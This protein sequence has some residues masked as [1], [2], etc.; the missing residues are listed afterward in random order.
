MGI[1]VEIEK[2][3]KTL[4]R[5]AALKERVCE[6]IQQEV[7]PHHNTSIIEVLKRDMVL[8]GIHKAND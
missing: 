2:A 7:S 6:Y 8:E 1:I 3:I 4:S 5:T